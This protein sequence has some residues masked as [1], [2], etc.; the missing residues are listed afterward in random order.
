MATRRNSVSYPFS[1][2]L[3]S[4]LLL[5]EIAQ[6]PELW[7]DTLERVDVFLSGRDEFPERVILTGAGTSAYAGQC[8][9]AAWP[10][11]SAIA[12]TD[13]MLL[14][15]A[16]I[17]SR[18]PGIAEDGLLISLARSGDSPESVGVVQRFKELYPAVRHLVITCNAEG[19][20]AKT[21]DVDVLTLSPRTNDR[22]LAMTG[23]FSSLAL[24]GLAL[25]HIDTL[26][27]HLPGICAAM[28]GQLGSMFDVA[29]E[30]VSNGAS[31]FVV[32]TS[33][34]PSL[35]I[36]TMLKVLELTSGRTQGMAESFLGFRHGANS[37]LRPE[38]PVLC[39]VSSDPLKRRYEAELVYDLRKRGM[40]NVCLVGQDEADSWPHR[41]WVPSLAPSLPDVLRIPF[42]VV[43]A[44]VFAYAAS[45]QAGVD[46]DNPS[47]G[48]EVTRVVRPFQV[49]H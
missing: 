24:A 35:S 14:S 36:E 17:E 7:G 16:E 30:M 48:G 23:S 15:S 6:Q 49:H 27:E 10:G 31:R 21:P 4:S 5:R 40:G 38:I 12:T 39:F 13:L 19:R 42:E 11:A 44:Q 26:R 3:E 22:S 46:P 8:I 9:A 25:K 43:F 34:M 2:Y 33:I 28:R 41:W 32:L 45:L 37:I 29:Q 20:L 47:P 1:K 18:V